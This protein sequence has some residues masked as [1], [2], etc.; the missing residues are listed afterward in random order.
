MRFFSAIGGAA[1]AAAFVISS[2]APYAGTLFSST[3]NPEGQDQQFM[4][5]F[6]TPLGLPPH[7][8]SFVPPVQLTSGYPFWVSGINP[9]VGGTENGPGWQSQRV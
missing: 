4:M 9:I 5:S 3:G 1:L 8:Y 2:G 6:A 7:H